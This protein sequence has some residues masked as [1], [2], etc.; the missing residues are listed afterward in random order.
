MNAKQIF[1]KIVLD[2]NAQEIGKIED[3]DINLDDFTIQSLSIT[4]KK[5]FTSKENI[6]V[7]CI[8]IKTIGQYVLLNNTVIKED[9]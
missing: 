3:F 8:D 4:L 5:G 6:I 1:G 2:K 7:D 9:E